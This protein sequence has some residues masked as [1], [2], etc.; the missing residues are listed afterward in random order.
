MLT[1]ENIAEMKED[2]LCKEV[3][4]PLLK[5]MGFK[6]VTYT[7]GGA[8]EQGKDIVCWKLNELGLRENF[9][10]VVKAKSINGKAQTGGGGNAGEVFMQISQT[11]GKDYI[12]PIMLQPQTVN[13]CWVV[14]NQAILTNAD[15]SIRSALGGAMAVR[16]VRFIDGGKLWELVEQYLGK[17]VV[18]QKLQ[19]L[20]SIFSNFDTHYSPIALVS[21]NEIHISL[22][23]KF[24]GAAQEKPIVIK[25]TFMFPDTVEGKRVRADFENHLSTGARISMPTSYFRIE[26][27]PDVLKPFFDQRKF[28]DGVLEIATASEH[29]FKA[30]LEVKTTDGDQ[31]SIDYIDLKVVKSGMNET[32]LETV[33]DSILIKIQIVL[34]HS[35]NSLVMHVTWDI[36]GKT[37]NVGQL[38]KVLNL[39]YCLS[40]SFTVKLIALEDQLIVLEKEGSSFCQPPVKSFTDMVHDLAN[41]QQKIKKPLMLPI[42]EYTEDE[43][44][45]INEIMTIFREAKRQAHWSNIE[46][47]IGNFD[48]TL[49]DKLSHQPMTLRLQSEKELDF[50]GVLI[51]LGRISYVLHGAYVEDWEVVR[52]K[53]DGLDDTAEIKLNF[54]SN[55]DDDALEVDYL[56]WQ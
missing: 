19:E 20:G 15:E 13:I 38:F 10:L 14:T 16:N 31:E 51:P 30:K 12:D 23:E 53:I 49:S 17:D 36:V 47:T 8:N 3:I 37:V 9:A 24:E 21:G 40:K 22:K 48:E 18:N 46:V 4:I 7:H 55:K 43:L 41:V 25:G 39:Q 11:F 32:T 5:A 27:I 35:N 34:N 28:E 42:R 6:D 52:A 44:K 54:Y 45:D 29:H 26:D 56:D 1:K 2:Q 33:D 50:F